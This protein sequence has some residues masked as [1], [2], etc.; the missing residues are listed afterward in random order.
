MNTEQVLKLIETERQRQLKKWG[1]QKHGHGKWLLILQEELGEV[2]KAVLEDSGSTN[3][4]YLLEE[5]V[6]SAAVITAWIEDYTRW[7]NKPVEAKT[8]QI[9]IDKSPFTDYGL[10]ESQ[11]L[12]L[13]D[14]FEE[15]RHPR[16]RRAVSNDYDVLL[17]LGLIKSQMLKSGRDPEYGYVPTEAGK[18]LMFKERDI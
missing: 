2:S 3:N 15:S 18:A 6:Q 1:D 8:K 7:T 16:V 11:H 5:L 4:P 12:L 9:S 13:R 17:M 10:T 14:I